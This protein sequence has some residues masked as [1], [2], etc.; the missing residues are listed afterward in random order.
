MRWSERIIFNSL[1]RQNN[2]EIWNH[3]YFLSTG[4]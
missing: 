3:A 4:Y 2:R 1:G